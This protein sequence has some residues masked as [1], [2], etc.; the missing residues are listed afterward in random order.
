MGK[1]KQNKKHKKQLEAHFYISEG[2]S[3]LSLSITWLGQGTGLYLEYEIVSHATNPLL[4][5]GHPWEKTYC[6]PFCLRRIKKM[7]LTEAKLEL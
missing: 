4:I 7:S 5:P 1:T 3:F 2:S 6:S